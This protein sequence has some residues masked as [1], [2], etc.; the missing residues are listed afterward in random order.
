M[1]KFKDGSGIEREIKLDTGLIEDVVEKHGIELDTLFMEDGNGVM[2]LI[3]ARPR[4]FSK[5]LAD[6]CRLS[7][8]EAKAFARSLNAESMESARTAF[9]DDLSSF[10]LPPGARGAFLKQ[11]ETAA[12]NTDLSDGSNKP[13]ESAAGS[14]A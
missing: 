4:I 14:S 6:L 12:M 3:Y 9:L 2:Q 5:V 13:T 7:G 8:E 11:V 1:A 10:F